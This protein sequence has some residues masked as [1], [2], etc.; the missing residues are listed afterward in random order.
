[1]KA[2]IIAIFEIILGLSVLA[3]TGWMFLFL[4]VKI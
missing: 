2:K 1:M 4:G 3:W